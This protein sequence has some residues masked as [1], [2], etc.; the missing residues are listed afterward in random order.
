MSSLEHTAAIINQM[1][2]YFGPGN[3]P[4]DT[5]L[6]KLMDPEGWVVLAQMCA[7]PRM[8]RLGATDAKQVAK[9]LLTYSAAIEVDP[10][11]EKV[12]P[13]YAQPHML[14]TF[15]PHHYQLM[16]MQHPL[17]HMLHPFQPAPHFPH[18]DQTAPI[19]V[20]Q[21]PAPP[22]HI[23][24][25]AYPVHPPC[26]PQ[27]YPYPPETPLQFG[28]MYAPLTPIHREQTGMLQQMAHP[29][30]QP[31]PNVGEHM[32]GAQGQYPHADGAEQA[33]DAQMQDLTLNQN[34]W[35]ENSNDSD[36]ESPDCL[37]QDSQ[38]PQADTPRPHQPMGYGAPGPAQIGG[39]RIPP[40][41]IYP[42]PMAMQHQTPYPIPQ[43]MQQPLPY[44]GEQKFGA[45]F[46]KPAPYAGEQGFS[47]QMQQPVLIQ[48][49]SQVSSN[50][51]SPNKPDCHE[52][53]FQVPR[54]D[55]RRPGQNMGYREAEA[56][57]MERVASEVSSEG[58]ESYHNHR[59]NRKQGAPFRG[60]SPAR[61]NKKENHR[62]DGEGHG[63][64]APRDM[65]HGAGFKKPYIR[66][67]R[68]MGHESGSGSKKKPFHRMYKGRYGNNSGH[69]GHEDK[70]E[71]RRQNPDLQ[72]KNFPP[73]PHANGNGSGQRRPK[74][75]KE[76][77]SAS[78]T[79]GVWANKPASVLAYKPVLLARARHRVQQEAPLTPVPVS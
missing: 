9:A 21:F 23:T 4:H 22:H 64:G 38:V 49:P 17:P 55:A 63:E 36:R 72:A 16:H 50:G 44:G 73:L 39:V 26:N 59:R 29:M 10:A 13:Q 77:R 12:R 68:Q 74:A 71:I 15:P 5:H 30:P 11:M 58:N 35:Q 18:P 45:Q 43:P 61:R 37:E 51:S 70:A 3:L 60:S 33:F 32:P 54:A 75:R 27:M 20:P 67:P 14:P 42:E 31:V 40:T 25:Q 56:L 1:E 78:P 2:F 79:G 53:D 41:P 6:H 34:P 19:F 28:T 57:Q 62:R 7:W 47:G 52:E 46:Q 48:T 24:T 69:R 8:V 65:H 66:Y 76:V